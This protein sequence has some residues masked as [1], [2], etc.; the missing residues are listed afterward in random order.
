M[1][2]LEV[3]GFYTW[4]QWYM[5]TGHFLFNKTTH[6]SPIYYTCTVVFISELPSWQRGEVGLGSPAMRGSGVKRT[7]RFS[8]EFKR[9]NRVAALIGDELEPLID[10]AAAP[11][12]PR[13]AKRI[14]HEQKMANVESQ[15]ARI[16]AFN[17]PTPPITAV[18]A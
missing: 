10:S 7:N 17:L 18:H 2:Y 15:V 6:N 3:N 1:I 8:E 13:M 9:Q 4:Y 16:A 5:R 11:M 12:S 14:H